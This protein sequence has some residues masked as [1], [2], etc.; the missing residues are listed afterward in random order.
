VGLNLDSSKRRAPL[1]SRAA[2]LYARSPS[3]NGQV[4]PAIGIGS[5]DRQHLG[6]IREAPNDG[7]PII[8]NKRLLDVHNVLGGHLD[9]T[10]TMAPES[11][12]GTHHARWP[13]TRSK[14]ANTVQVLKPLAVRTA[15]LLA[16]LGLQSWADDVVEFLNQHC[17]R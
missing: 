12:Y 3:R 5:N 17:H 14:Q 8:L 10:A 11:A 1:A 6:S 13:E 16:I 7:D 4:Q 15:T 2:T 9:Q